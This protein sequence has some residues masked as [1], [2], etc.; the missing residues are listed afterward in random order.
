MSKC[1]Q[2]IL[3][4][5]QDGVAFAVRHKDEPV[6]EIDGKI[7]ADVGQQLFVDQLVHRASPP[8]VQVQ[9]GFVQVG[10]G[11]AVSNTG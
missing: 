4:G 8:A 11:Y 10:L 9:A 6:G 3:A 2:D 5:W 1:V 7:E